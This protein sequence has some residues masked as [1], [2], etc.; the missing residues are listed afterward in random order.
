MWHLVFSI[1]TW[2]KL[3]TWNLL[4]RWIVND[5][6]YLIELNYWGSQYTLTVIY[7][8]HRDCI[9]QLFIKDHRHLESA[10]NRLGWSNRLRR[11]HENMY[12]CCHTEKF[13]EESWIKIIS[14][15]SQTITVVLGPIVCEIF[16]MWT[17][18]STTPTNFKNNLLTSV[19]RSVCIWYRS[20]TSSHIST[21]I[22]RFQSQ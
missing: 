14:D 18:R 5:V 17:W 8:R 22:L 11:C 16:L 6:V 15:K 12:L 19:W 3:Y 1:G 10:E 9:R 7:L 2:L 21:R 13:R 20:I 4:K